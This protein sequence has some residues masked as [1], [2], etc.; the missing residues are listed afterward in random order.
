MVIPG[1][2]YETSAGGPFF[3][4]IDFQGSESFLFL[5]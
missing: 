2:S 1:V 3:R 5:A 4:D